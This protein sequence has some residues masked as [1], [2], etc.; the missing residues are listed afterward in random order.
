MLILRWSIK[1]KIRI[2][3]TSGR[4]IGPFSLDRVPE[5][6]SKGHIRGDEEFQIFPGGTWGEIDEHPQIKAIVLKLLNNEPVTIDADGDSSS[7]DSN[8]SEEPETKPESTD[9][10][11]NFTKEFGVAKKE[12]TKTFNKSDFVEF[13]ADK[14]IVNKLQEDIVLDS[15]EKTKVVRLQEKV[16]STVIKTL[17]PEEMAEVKKLEEEREAEEKAKIEAEKQRIA[18]ESKSEEEEE[19]E[20]EVDYEN[21]ATVVTNIGNLLPELK[22]N[23]KKTEKEFKKKESDAEDLDKKK[24]K[25]KKEKKKKK[26]NSENSKKL[27]INKKKMT[28]IV[29]FAFLALAYMLIVDDGGEGDKFKPIYPKFDFPVPNQYIDAQKA[30]EYFEKGKKAYS[31]NTYIGDIKASRNYVISL[32]HQFQK[33]KAFENLLEVYSELLPFSKSPISDSQKVYD[34]VVLGKKSQLKNLKVAIGT[35]QFYE[36][37]KKYKAGTRIIERFLRAGNSPS[38]KLFAVYMRL[39]LKDGD[40]QKAKKAYDKLTS[41]PN[42][43]EEVWLSLISYLL[44]EDNFKEARKLCEAAI[45]EYPN[46][47]ELYLEYSKVLIFFEDIK[48]LGKVLGR[49]KKLNF[50]NNSVHYAKFLELAGTL[51]GINGDFKKA[52]RYY[53]L[54]LKMDESDKLRSRLSALE[55]GGDEETKNIILESKGYDLQRKAL[56][57]ML[58]KNWDKAFKFALEAVDILPHDIDGKL[59][60]AE[61]LTKRGFFDRSISILSELE[62]KYPRNPRIKFKLT[63]VYIDSFKLTEAQA[64]LLKMRET[65]WKSHYMFASLFGKYYLKS[66]NFAL[67]IKWLRESINRNPLNDEDEALIAKA[68]IQKGKFQRAKNRIRKAID[69]DPENVEYKS[70]YG[71]ILYEFDSAEIAIGYLRDLLREFPDNPRLLGDIAIYYYRSG[72]LKAFSEQIKEIEKLPKRD[73]NVY[74]LLIRASKIDN[75][76][77]DTLKYFSELFK[78]TPGDLKM[79]MDYGEYLADQGKLDLALKQFEAIKERLE[80]Y[81]LVYYNIAKVHFA[82]GSWEKAKENA[83]KE[84]ANTPNLEHGYTIYGRSMLELKEYPEAIKA[85]RKALSINRKSVDATMAMAYIKHK[86]D[87]IDEALNLYLFAQKAN[88]NNPEIHRRLGHIY[89]DTGQAALAIESFQV[90]LN[91]NP[92]AKDKGQ[93]EA[94]INSLR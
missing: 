41:I 81:P 74:K 15:G 67:A 62:D 47:V 38:P 32:R 46:S 17:T 56:N 87:H 85:L 83:E 4:V 7:E 90:Y 13:K 89:K 22:K 59:I 11:I 69:L 79:R 55:I 6:Y 24:E 93:I 84:I 16:D 72:Q 50:A 73:A 18:E 91:L 61:I 78:I 42:K 71:S 10:S 33:N 68:F 54:A 2:R 5:L 80:S 23:V 3:D 53:K 58:E 45:K 64:L 60:F 30:K 39:L 49:I 66:D 51:S 86:Q 31:Y 77:E 75:R 35:S 76:K 26:K 70:I 8:K 92:A 88:P 36:V 27:K 29:A 34:L 94:L 48:L 20:E 21:E 12:P 52:L 28:P 14:K 9:S 37:L 57:A 44:A 65:K 40:F 63:E 25:K 82:K 1:L 19:Q 43:S